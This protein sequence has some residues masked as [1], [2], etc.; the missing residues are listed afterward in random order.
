MARV[1]DNPGDYRVRQQSDGTFR[2]SGVKLTGQR[3]KQK[4]GSKDEADT[5]AALN[6]KSDVKLDDWGLPLPGDMKMPADMA[7]KV[8]ATMGIP[9]PIVTPKTPEQSKLA[10]STKKRTVGLMGMVGMGW[11]MGDVYVARRMTENLGKDPVNPDPDTVKELGK[12]VT[13]TLID[14]FGEKE[15]KPWMQALLLTI[16]LPVSM[17]IQSPKKK[18]VKPDHLKSVP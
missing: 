12:A 15:V 2:V 6:F 1:A 14:W 10:E 7:S 8:N 16:A 9:T 3:V 13:D 18:E 17:M 11:A 5:Y 4:F